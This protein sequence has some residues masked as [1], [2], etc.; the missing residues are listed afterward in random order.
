MSAKVLLTS[1]DISRALV[2]VAHEILERNHGAESVVL[3]GVRTRG[4]PLAE[5]LQKI[6]ETFEQSVVP[7]GA[8]DVLAY[9]DDVGFGLSHSH[10]GMPH[11]SRQKVAAAV[12]GRSGIDAPQDMALA[13][14]LP[15]L[16]NHLPFSIADRNVVLVDD[17][18]YTGRTIRAAMD[19]VVDLGRPRSIQL[20]VLVDRGHRE[21]PIRPDYV[22]KNI[23]S[24]RNELVRVRLLETDGE[25]S[26][27][28]VKR[29]VDEGGGSEHC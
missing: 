15:S 22:G 2:R 23:P 24:A 20:A 18:L 6:I 25:D 3:V 7:V 28:I 27:S 1:T 19:A 13:G 17:V 26:V 10:T 21:L 14:S 11:I 8:L 12:A 16:P 9:R 5:R 29:L 4:F